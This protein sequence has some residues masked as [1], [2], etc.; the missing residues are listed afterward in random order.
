MANITSIMNKV[1]RNAQ[2]LGLTVSAQTAN[3][4]SIAADGGA[5]LTVA[6]ALA[7]ILPPMGGVDPT[8]SPYLGIG[9]ANPGQLTLT[10]TNTGG[11]VA[12]VINGPIS[13]QVLCMLAWFANDIILADATTPVSTANGY[14][15]GIARLRGDS[16]MIG[17][18][19]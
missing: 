5:T 7:A 3:S 13:A 14:A 9:I 15:Q 6:Y 17:V 1:A 19:Q 16:D 8:V 2:V 4:V 11:A 12:D 18:G 10:S